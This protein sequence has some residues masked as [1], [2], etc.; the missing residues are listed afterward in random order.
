[1]DVEVALLGGGKK[2][3]RAPPQVRALAEKLVAD[4]LR[5]SR[6]LTHDGFDLDAAMELVS[7]YL[8]LEEEKLGLQQG[9]A[10]WGTEIVGLG[11]GEAAGSGLK[12]SSIDLGGGAVDESFEDTLAGAYAVREKLESDSDKRRKSLKQVGKHLRRRSQDKIGEVKVRGGEVREKV[13]E[14]VKE[15]RGGGGARES[16]LK[17]RGGAAKSTN[18]FD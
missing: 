10:E 11:G 5:A 2:T 14:K 13:L 18:P 9:W 17:A 8:T 4:C 15:V 12:S 6:A 3:A 7:S 16:P 1:M